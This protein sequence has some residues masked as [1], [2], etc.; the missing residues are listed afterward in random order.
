MSSQSIKN[1][2]IVVGSLVVMNRGCTFW[3]KH[4]GIGFRNGSQLGVVT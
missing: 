4:V 1:N 2:C 3:Q